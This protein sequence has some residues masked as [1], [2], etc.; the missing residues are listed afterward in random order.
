MLKFSDIK[1]IKNKVKA[2]CR[3]GYG[4]VPVLKGKP[5]SGSVSVCV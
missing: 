4:R 2:V 1:D 5:A 3:Q